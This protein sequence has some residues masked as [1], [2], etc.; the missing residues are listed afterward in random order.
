MCVRRQS[1]RCSVLNKGCW[2]L[3]LLL[4]D[5]RGRWDPGAGPGAV[6]GCGELPNHVTWTPKGARGG[7]CLR[8]GLR[9]VCNYS[10]SCPGT[11]GFDV[12]FVASVGRA[13]TTKNV[14]GRCSTTSGPFREAESFLL[15]EAFERELDHCLSAALGGISAGGLGLYLLVSN[16]PSRLTSVLCPPQALGERPGGVGGDALHVLKVRQLVAGG[17][18]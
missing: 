16:R 13:G 9:S 10:G 11:C 7:A 5:L 2:V 1:W 12:N 14:A 15:Q 3:H 4:L 17:G 6:P 18:E 8:A